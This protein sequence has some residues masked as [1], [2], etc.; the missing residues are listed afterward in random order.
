MIKKTVI[1]IKKENYLK[2]MFNLD[3]N[4]F[5]NAIYDFL[6][7]SMTPEAA[8]KKSEDMSNNIIIIVDEIYNH[9]QT[10]TDELLLSS[11]FHTLKSHLLFGDFYYESDL[12]QDIEI[13]LRKNK[14]I[15]NISFLF[16]ELLKSLKM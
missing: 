5:Y 12:C 1:I 13:E 10:N 16:E 8:K 3:S 15:S 9:I 14:N 4:K 11:R 7:E 2:L 6:S